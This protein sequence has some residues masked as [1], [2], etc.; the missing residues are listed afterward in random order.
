MIDFIIVDDFAPQMFSILVTIP[1][2]VFNVIKKRAVVANMFLTEVHEIP[3]FIMIG[4]EQARVIV[5]AKA[6]NRL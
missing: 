4:I 3:F 6:K 1:K 5:V 2:T